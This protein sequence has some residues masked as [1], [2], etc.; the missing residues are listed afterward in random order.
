MAQFEIN[1][2]T[3]RAGK[4]DAFKQFHVS[5]RIAPIIPTLI[6]VFLRLANDG[7]IVKNLD[8]L[9]EVLGPF[10]DGIAAMSDES[11]EFVIGTCLSV[12]QRQN[13]SLW[14]PVWNSQQKVCMF[15]DLDLG[16]MIQIVLRVLQDNLGPFM[17]GLLTS[18]T[19]DPQQQG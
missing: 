18:P 11:S 5:R 10:A 6:P 19:S 9:A 13:G 4:M 17:A 7:S 14:A 2:Q 8:A 12:V 1:G 3:Y 15:D 16:A